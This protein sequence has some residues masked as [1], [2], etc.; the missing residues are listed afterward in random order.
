MKKRKLTS[1]LQNRFALSIVVAT[2]IVLVVSALL[3][4]IVLIFAI[5]VVSTRAQDEVVTLSKQHLWINPDSSPGQQNYTEA[6]LA[7]INTKG[8]DIVIE[9]ITICGKDCPWN[10]VET[11]D[12][13]TT[14]QFIEYYITKASLSNDLH[15]QPNLNAGPTPT[16]T[17]NHVTLDGV[18]CTFRVAADNLV[19]SAGYTMIIYIINP[20]GIDINDIGL[21]V[22]ITLFTSQ[23]VYHTEGNVQVYAP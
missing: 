4:S 5:N 6:A 18:D 1:I 13:I 16:P 11:V 22:G 9:K 21:T 19:L 7:V 15:F 23:Q 10:A 3:S 20:T 12:G 17:D 8:R 2:L 14:G